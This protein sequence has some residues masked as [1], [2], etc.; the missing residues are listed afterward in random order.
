MINVQDS[1]TTYGTDFEPWLDV[2]GVGLELHRTDVA[3]TGK[4]VAGEFEQW[5]GG[6]QTVGKIAVI[7]IDGVDQPVS[8][9]AAVDC[10]LPATGIAKD[11][12]LSQDGRFIAWTDDQGLKVA[13]TPA[14]PPTRAC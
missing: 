2:S 6:R 7:S 5:N 4:L 11:V 10:F 3:A 8:F 9:P 1:A 13:G 12:S 14:T